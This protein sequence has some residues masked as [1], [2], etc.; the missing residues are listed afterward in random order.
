MSRYELRRF[1][2][3]T[4][5]EV[6]EDGE[7]IAEHDDIYALARQ[8]NTNASKIMETIRNGHKVRGRRFVINTARTDYE[9]TSNNVQNT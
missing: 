3:T 4:L 2:G 9:L 1:N 7:I 8:L 5:F 6:N